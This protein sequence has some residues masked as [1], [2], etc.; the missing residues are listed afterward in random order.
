MKNNRNHL[1][2]YKK[3]LFWVIAAIAFACIPASVLGLS[4]LRDNAAK[5]PD[6][7]DHTKEPTNI[8]KQPVSTLTLDDVLLLSHKGSDLTWEDFDSYHYMETGFGLYIRTYDIDDRF[9]LTIGSGGS[10]IM[11]IHLCCSASNQ[12]IDIRDT[13]AVENFIAK[14][15]T[16]N[17]LDSASL[18]IPYRSS[19]FLVAPSDGKDAFDK[20][21]E[22]ADNKN[23]PT[24][25][26]NCIMNLP[27]VRIRNRAELDSFCKEMSGD[28]GFTQGY[29]ETPSFPEASEKYGEAFFETNSL[30]LIFAHSSGSLESPEVEFIYRHSIALS[31]GIMVS[32]VAEQDAGWLIAIEAANE[33]I[34]LVASVDSYVSSYRLHA[35]N[36]QAY[37]GQAQNINMDGVV[38]SFEESE[39]VIKPSIT[40]YDNRTFEF[41]FSV[42][43]SYPGYGSYTIENGRLVLCTD[44]GK[45]TYAFDMIND[46]FIFDADASSEPSGYSGIYD[47]AVFKIV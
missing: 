24:R 22:L 42:P 1:P 36:A 4:H 38:Y 7:T 31:I 44:D 26:L 30:F 14:N 41:T 20:M 37:D 6:N 28:L 12:Y 35:G 11:Y 32:P 45:Y 29:N 27:V 3:T 16:G 21:F 9:Y 19:G 25:T 13:A 15:L 33:D 39:D 10:D 17:S 40:L 5:K 43:S 46:A 2:L 8:E 34:S 18:E 23:S 47:G